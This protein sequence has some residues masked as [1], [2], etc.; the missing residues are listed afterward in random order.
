[1]CYS[2]SFDQNA[3][4]VYNL[5]DSLYSFLNGREVAILGNR[6]STTCTRLNEMGRGA[7]GVREAFAPESM[8]CNTEGPQQ[9][10]LS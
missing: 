3:K 9:V 2:K 6:T 8:L 7:L 4:G 10:W 1:M 5:T